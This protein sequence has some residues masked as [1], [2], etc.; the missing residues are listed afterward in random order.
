MVEPQWLQRAGIPGVKAC[1]VQKRKIFLDFNPLRISHAPDRNPMWEEWHC[2]LH[3][4]R[5]YKQDH[6][7]LLDYFSRIY[8]IKDAFGKTVEPVFDVSFDNWIGK[9]GWRRVMDEIE[10]I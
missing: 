2:Y 1:G 6:E 9:D 8:P 5:I 4:L 10:G 3:P 7:L